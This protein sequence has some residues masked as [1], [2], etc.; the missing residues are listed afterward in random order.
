MDTLTAGD[1][2]VDFI[3]GGIDGSK[4]DSRSARTKGL[5]MY[6]FWK[7]GCGTCR[8]TV[9]FLQRFHEQYASD[10]FK[11]WGVSQDGKLETAEFCKAFALTFPQALDLDL[12]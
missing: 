2:V 3:L 4:C 6:A 8:Y 11:I 12:N 9:P 5:L 7:Q 1:K 10:G